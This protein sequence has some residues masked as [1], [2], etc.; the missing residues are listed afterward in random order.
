MMMFMNVNKLY[1]K[2]PKYKTTKASELMI[3]A[4]ECFIICKNP[5]NIPEDRP[6]G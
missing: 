5:L 2:I 6:T 3:K 1:Q 4:M